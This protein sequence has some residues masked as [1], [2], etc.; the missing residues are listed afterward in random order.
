MAKSRY[1]APK[2]LIQAE[3]LTQYGAEYC[4]DKIGQTTLDAL[5]AL[6][7]DYQRAV[8]LLGKDK[9]SKDIQII[10]NGT[11]GFLRKKF[12]YSGV[13]SVDC[14]IGA[15]NSA[16]KKYRA[17]DLKCLHIDILIKLVKENSKVYK[18][19]R[20]ENPLVTKTWLHCEFSPFPDELI[21]FNP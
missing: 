6:R 2:E 5:D 1:F 21:I 16:H 15:L 20:I 19:S 18:I 17:F 8:E 4:M 7:Y 12:K 11:W 10:I 14:K 3:L 13:R 9:S